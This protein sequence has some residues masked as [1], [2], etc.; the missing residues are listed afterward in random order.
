MYVSNNKPVWTI[1][2][3]VREENYLYPDVRTSM[4]TTKRSAAQKVLEVEKSYLIERGYKYYDERNDYGKLT[5]LFYKGERVSNSVYA[6]IT[7][8]TSAIIDSE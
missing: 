8:Q 4:V 1:V 6:T 7:I 2:V 3:T 5:Y